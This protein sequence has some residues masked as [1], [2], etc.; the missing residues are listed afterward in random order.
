MTYIQAYHRKPLTVVDS[1]DRVNYIEAFKAT[2]EE[3][4]TSKIISF[5]AAQHARGL[6][7]E[8]EA[9]KRSQKQTE[10]LKNRDEGYSLIF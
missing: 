6:S 1:N 7:T 3:T 8:I 4:D 10:K 5:L 2:R 9:F